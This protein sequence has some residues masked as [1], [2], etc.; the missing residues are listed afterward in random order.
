MF[1]IFYIA[2]KEQ[3]NPIPLNIYHTA[4]YTVGTIGGWLS[5]NPVLCIGIVYGFMGT[6]SVHVVHV[7]AA[8]AFYLHGNLIGGVCVGSMLLGQAVLVTLEFLG[9][10]QPLAIRWRYNAAFAT[11]ISLFMCLVGWVIPR[12]PVG[13]THL[14]GIRIFKPFVQLPRKIESLRDPRVLL[15]SVLCASLY[16]LIPRSAISFAND[17]TSVLGFSHGTKPAFLWGTLLGYGIG[18]L[19]FYASMFFIRSIARLITNKP[20]EEFIVHLISALNAMVYATVIMQFRTFAP[21]FDFEENSRTYLAEA[22]T[23]VLLVA[24]DRA[25]DWVPSVAKQRLALYGRVYQVE[26]EMGALNQL[27]LRSV[28]D[29]KNSLQSVNLLPD[30]CEQPAF[31]SLEPQIGMLP[32]AGLSP[33][34]EAFSNEAPSDG[35]SLPSES[36]EGETILQTKLVQAELLKSPEEQDTDLDLPEL[37]ENYPIEPPYEKITPQEYGEESRGFAFPWEKKDLARRLGSLSLPEGRVLGSWHPQHFG[38]EAEKPWPTI[39]STSQEEQRPE[40][41]PRK[42]MNTDWGEAT[43]SNVK[44]YSYTRLDDFKQE[45]ADLVEQRLEEGFLP[46]VP[47]SLRML[48]WYARATRKPI[49]AQSA[50]KKLLPLGGKNALKQIIRRVVSEKKSEFWRRRNPKQLKKRL[51]GGSVM[52]QRVDE[53]QDLDELDDA[54]ELGSPLQSPNDILLT[55]VPL[56]ATSEQVRELFEGHALER[57]RRVFQLWERRSTSNA[58]LLFKQRTKGWFNSEDVYQDVVQRVFSPNEALFDYCVRLMAYAQHQRAFACVIRPQTHLAWAE[59]DRAPRLCLSMVPGL[60]RTRPAYQVQ[61]R[62]ADIYAYLYGE[63]K[64]AKD[65]MEELRLPSPPEERDRGLLATRCLRKPQMLAILESRMLRQRAD[66]GRRVP[67]RLESEGR[68]ILPSS[69]AHSLHSWAEGFLTHAAG[70]L[71]EKI[72]RRNVSE[73]IRPTRPLHT[74]AQGQP[75]ASRSDARLPTGPPGQFPFLLV[76]RLLKA[77]KKGSLQPSNKRLPFPQLRSLVQAPGLKSSRLGPGP[78][79]HR[80]GLLSRS[81]DPITANLVATTPAPQGPEDR[82]RRQAL[83]KQA[84][85]P[86]QQ[87]KRKLEWA[88]RKMARTLDQCEDLSI[89]ARPKSVLVDQPRQSLGGRIVSPK[90]G[91][92]Q[93][94]HQPETAVATSGSQ[95]VRRRHETSL[96]RRNWSPEDLFY[97]PLSSL[98]QPLQNVF[99]QPPTLLLGSNRQSWPSAQLLSEGTPKSELLQERVRPH[100]LPTSSKRI[101]RRINHACE[102]T[103][104]EVREALWRLQ[105]ERGREAR[106]EV[107]DLRVSLDSLRQVTDKARFSPAVPWILRQALLYA[108]EKEIA[109]IAW[110]TLYKKSGTWVGS[111]P[112][113]SPL[114][115]A[116]SD[117]GHHTKAHI[118]LHP[119]RHILQGE[120]RRIS[121]WSG[122]IEAVEKERTTPRQLQDRLGIENGPDWVGPLEDRWSNLWRQRPPGAEK[123]GHRMLLALHRS[124]WDKR[125]LLY[126]PLPPLLGKT[127]RTRQEELNRFSSKKRKRRRKRALIKHKQQALIAKQNRESNLRLML[128][129]SLRLTSLR[130]YEQEGRKALASLAGLGPLPLFADDERV[131]ALVRL[132]DS[133]VDPSLRRRAWGARYRLAL[134]RMLARVDKQKYSFETLKTVRR[135]T[136]RYRVWDSMTQKHILQS[137][138]ANLGLSDRYKQGQALELFPPAFS[139]GDELE[140]SQMT[141]G[142][143]DTGIEPYEKGAP[144]L[145]KRKKKEGG[146]NQTARPRDRQGE[147]RVPETREEEDRQLPLDKSERL[148][149]PSFLF[150][151]EP[152]FRSLDDLKEYT[153]YDLPAGFMNGEDWWE[154]WWDENSPE[155]NTLIGPNKWGII[156][157]EMDERDAASSL[158]FRKV[159]QHNSHVEARNPSRARIVAEEWFAQSSLPPGERRAYLD[160]QKGWIEEVEKRKQKVIR[161]L[162][163]RSLRRAWHRRL[164][165]PVNRVNEADRWREIISK[166]K[167]H[168]PLGPIARFHL[169]HSG[170]PEERALGRVPMDPHITDPE[171]DMFEPEIVAEMRKQRMPRLSRWALGELRSRIEAD[172]MQEGVRKDIMRRAW[173]RGDATSWATRSGSPPDL[174]AILEY[175]EERAEEQRGTERLHTSALDQVAIRDLYLMKRMMRRLRLAF[176]LASL[177]LQSTWLKSSNPQR[178]RRPTQFEKAWAWRD[179]W[180]FQSVMK[181]NLINKQDQMDLDDLEAGFGSVGIEHDHEAKAPKVPS[182]TDLL[183]AADSL[184]FWDTN[185]REGS[186]SADGLELFK[187]P[188]F[189]GAAGRF[190]SEP[191]AQSMDKALSDPFL[192]KPFL[193]SQRERLREL[194][195]RQAHLGGRC[196][197]AETTKQKTLAQNSLGAQ[198]I[199]SASNL[200]E[201]N[202]KE[203]PDLKSWQPK[204]AVRRLGLSGYLMGVRRHIEWSQG[205]QPFLPYLRPS[206]GLVGPSADR[207][208]TLTK[209]NEESFWSAETTGYQKFFPTYEHRSPWRQ[210]WD[211]MF[212]RESMKARP[213]RRR[214]RPGCPPDTVHSLSQGFLGIPRLVKPESS[215]ARGVGP[216]SLRQYKNYPST[217]E[218][219]HP[220][221][222][223]QRFKRKRSDKFLEL[224]IS[225][226]EDLRRLTPLIDENPEFDYFLSSEYETLQKLPDWDLL[227]RGISFV[228]D[229]ETM[230][231]ASQGPEY[232]LRDKDGILIFLDEYSRVLGGIWV[233]NFVEIANW[234]LKVNLGILQGFFRSF[235][236]ILPTSDSKAY[237][238][239]AILG[240]PQLIYQP[241]NKGFFSWTEYEN[242][243]REGRWKRIPSFV[244]RMERSCHFTDHMIAVRIKNPF[245]LIQLVFQAF[246][247]N[248]W[249]ALNEIEVQTYLLP[250]RE[251]DMLNQYHKLQTRVYRPD[252]SAEGLRRY[253]SPF[254]RIREAVTKQLWG[255]FGMTR[256]PYYDIPYINKRIPH[257][258]FETYGQV[259][260]V[261][262]WW[263]GM[264]LQGYDWV[265]KAGSSR[266]ANHFRH[267]I[268]KRTNE[269]WFRMM[270][271]DPRRLE[272]LSSRANKVGSRRARGLPHYTSIKDFTIRGPLR[273]SDKYM[274]AFT[275]KVRI[276]D[277]PN[278]QHT[279][280]VHLKEQLQPEL[281]TQETQPALN[282]QETQPALNTQETQPTLNTQ[283]TQPALNTQESLNSAQ[284]LHDREGLEYQKQDQN[285]LFTGDLLQRS[286]ALWEKL[287]PDPSRQRLLRRMTKIHR[288]ALGHKLHLWV[289][290]LWQHSSYSLQVPLPL[291][292]K[293]GQNLP[294]TQKSYTE[295]VMSRLKTLKRREREGRQFALDQERAGREALASLIRHER[296]R[297]WREWSSQA[298]HKE[299]S[300]RPEEPQMMERVFH[301]SL[302]NE[303]HTVCL[304]IQGAWS[305]LVYVARFFVLH[306]R[307]EGWTMLSPWRQA[308]LWDEAGALWRQPSSSYGLLSAENVWTSNRILTRQQNSLQ[309][310]RGTLSWAEEALPF[311]SVSH[312]LVRQVQDMA[313]LASLRDVESTV[314]MAVLEGSRLLHQESPENQALDTKLYLLERKK[315]ERAMS[316]A[317]SLTQAVEERL[318]RQGMTKMERN[319]LESCKRCLERATACLAQSPVFNPQEV[320]EKDRISLEE[321]AMKWESLALLRSGSNLEKHSKGPLFP[322]RWNLSQGERE[323]LILKQKSLVRDRILL[324]RTVEIERLVRGTCSAAFHLSQ[325]QRQRL[326]VLFQGLALDIHS[327]EQ[328]LKTPRRLREPMSLIEGKRLWSRR[329]LSLREGTLRSM[330]VRLRE[331]A[332]VCLRAA[333]KSDLLP[334]MEDR[335]NRRLRLYARHRK[336]M[337]QAYR[338]SQKALE[339]KLLEVPQAIERAVIGLRESRPGLEEALDLLRLYMGGNGKEERQ[340]EEA[341]GTWVR[342]EM[343]RLMV[344]L[345]DFNL[346]SR[347]L[348]HMLQQE[349]TKSMPV[350]VPSPMLHTRREIRRLHTPW[351]LA[352]RSL[353]KVEIPLEVEWQLRTLNKEVES[354]SHNKHLQERL[355]LERGARLGLLDPENSARLEKLKQQ[356]LPEPGSG[357][358]SEI[359]EDPRMVNLAKSLAYVKRVSTSRTSPAQLDLVNYVPGSDDDTGLDWEA[360]YNYYGIEDWDGFI[361]DDL[362]S[363][364]TLPYDPDDGFLEDLWAWENRQADTNIPWSPWRESVHIECLHWHA[365]QD[366]RA[367]RALMGNSKHKPAMLDIHTPLDPILF[368]GPVQPQGVSPSLDFPLIGEIENPQMQRISRLKS[369][370]Y[371]EKT[372]QALANVLQPLP[373]MKVRTLGWAMGVVQRKFVYSPPLKP[374]RQEDSIGQ[375]DSKDLGREARQNIALWQCQAIGRVDRSENTLADGTWMNRLASHALLSPHEAF[376]RTYQWVYQRSTW[377]NSAFY[378]LKS[379]IKAWSHLPGELFQ[380]NPSRTQDRSQ[381]MGHSLQTWAQ[382]QPTWTM[383]QSTDQPFQ[384]NE[385][386][387]GLLWDLPAKKLPIADQQST[388]AI[389]EKNKQDRLFASKALLTHMLSSSNQSNLRL[390]ASDLAQEE[391]VVRRRYE[392]KVRHIGNRLPEPIPLQPFFSQWMDLQVSKLKGYEDRPSVS[393]TMA[394]ST[395]DLY[396]TS[397]GTLARPMAHQMSYSFHGLPERFIQKAMYSLRT[398]HASPTWWRTRHYFPQNPYQQTWRE[399]LKPLRR[400]LR[401]KGFDWI[402]R[403]YDLIWRAEMAGRKA[404]IPGLGRSEFR[405]LLAEAIQSKSERFKLWARN[406]AYKLLPTSFW[407]L[408]PKITR[409][410]NKANQNNG[411]RPFWSLFQGLKDRIRRMQ[412]WM[413]AYLQRFLRAFSSRVQD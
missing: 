73:P 191:L 197:S 6:Q 278:I 60:P 357:V 239:F 112:S 62:I 140:R 361:T 280:K 15:Y 325:L 396:M 143:F 270:V 151:P 362:L 17:L 386:R 241:S 134:A 146:A 186:P 299:I 346:P 183:D 148:S 373:R 149:S 94:M 233:G 3:M 139:F 366:I 131:L 127:L 56:P 8:R 133:R 243:V 68:L 190:S 344:A 402:L 82:A 26:E 407:H 157:E 313:H 288:R 51:K 61:E 404:G 255:F 267:P 245:Q 408:V 347:Q 201:G 69:V 410:T 301:G 208:N 293:L 372:N 64:E 266:E 200:K 291:L 124:Q 47:D 210:L 284:E 306:W 202:L 207:P 248:P 2:K 329:A 138:L 394:I 413:I 199:Q 333:P 342:E 279:G 242:R 182:L 326:L 109:K 113:L 212:G 49:W 92:N 368:M 371:E 67:L 391:Q 95:E 196:R 79:C 246:V 75:W 388:A 114:P 176:Q 219:F 144:T 44:P 58:L 10:S 5:V 411:A 379:R 187:E 19:L 65:M 353:P 89:W 31:R 256:V 71:T 349:A 30:L 277:A 93:S 328:A 137:E 251:Y 52:E 352:V 119:V 81:M 354:F 236:P 43:L 173:E 33:R 382:V 205:H 153:R 90:P 128:T 412:A 244:G 309:A 72:R 300:F 174:E 331:A 39:L 21:T 234:F 327:T 24:Q 104:K 322:L 297:G 45:K 228:M 232:D 86:K 32:A 66:Q 238:T 393:R 336:G 9:W 307:Q 263:L 390:V 154:L 383:S 213:M 343:A 209:L 330:P 240:K 159:F 217:F 102:R 350:A 40:S 374:T 214:L 406:K 370:T 35:K 367:W 188:G 254:I 276:L 165:R 36:E 392:R 317:S 218:E 185:L 105:G 298:H 115:I 292:S 311:G 269:E 264:D 28:V 177:H 355:S 272:S 229:M 108:K 156:E 123:R 395:K 116:P 369:P 18:D 41:G 163:D 359:D 76:P 70:F 335:I 42:N 53:M 316:L 285:D 222:K 145:V 118:Q 273:D 211:E 14:S 155:E 403:Q 296:A 310:G 377:T 54:F 321:W 34:L 84:L 80:P 179:F 323:A 152:L 4:L 376:K 378:W 27:L 195:A 308:K 63:E 38:S 324:W 37:E 247:H 77:L 261:E 59:L 259:P 398:W 230:V 332:L 389:A 150:K 237:M 189:L 206:M 287:A 198:R 132:D 348:A 340:V 363:G 337:L 203:L 397:M 99:G 305:S 175:E 20:G 314:A 312:G 320:W 126:N 74:Y 194:R 164:S 85:R 365:V 294:L 260:G 399:R 405:K 364:D 16:V 101:Q 252:N 275:K 166:S 387:Q 351:G 258:Y 103:E 12:R 142:L 226:E 29:E 281:N 249:K 22:R 215:R 360:D 265:K 235:S 121:P 97:A 136:H 358:M 262:P 286:L 180:Q 147:G 216:A 338:E 57:L 192:V 375:G 46:K 48:K 250:R 334:S 169:G 167:H 129:H 225:E 289:G 295:G 290:R 23:Q 385:E 106:Q 193:P 282:T 227:R 122:F 409:S 302:K 87:G 268:P 110:R 283:E 181:E 223:G 160:E 78:V 120:R 135:E 162:K 271:R 341:S 204:A 221:L 257:W 55:H 220:K 111:T 170:L 96:N 83:R 304:S 107:F 381:Q 400:S 274:K 7:L 178:M 315:V 380:L 88:I 168:Y 125:S 356:V 172:D 100:R 231:R 141:L 253:Y 50:R 25:S 130:L 319:A 224:G 11:G 1:P 171:L 117:S 401:D 384:G 345:Y 339:R 161:S 318:S 303:A 13:A 158:P 98:L 91:L 184:L